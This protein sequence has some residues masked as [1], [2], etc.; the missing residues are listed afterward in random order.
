[1]ESTAL[2]TNT[3]GGARVGAGAPVSSRTLETQKMRELMLKRLKPR[4][5]EVF[6]ALIDAAVGLRAARK[7]ESVYSKAP[8][9][10]AARLLFEYALGK[11][12]GEVEHIG[13]MSIYNLVHSLEYGNS[14]KN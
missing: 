2:K 9:V 7:D 13:G 12:K 10:Q 6:D 1:M 4:A 8:D 11:P 3:W 14:T 5:K